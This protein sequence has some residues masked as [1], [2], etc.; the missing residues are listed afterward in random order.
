MAIDGRTASDIL[1]S[2]YINKGGVDVS[3]SIS[4]ASS[5]LFCVGAQQKKVDPSTAVEFKAVDTVTSL[6]VVR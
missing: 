6:L 5:S 3:H 4:L 1:T 2:L